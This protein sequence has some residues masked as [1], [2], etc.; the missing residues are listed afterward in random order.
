[1]KPLVVLRTGDPPPSIVARRGPF[2][3]WIKREVGDRWAGPWLEHDVRTGAPP[4]PEEVSGFILTGSSHSVTERAPWMLR[5][6]DLVRRAHGAGTPVFGICFGH[7][8][9]GQALGGEVQ[10]N[11]RGREIGTVAVRLLAA[12]S[13]EPMLRGLGTPFF[14]NHSHKDSVVTLPAG[15]RVLGETDLEPHAILDFG[16]RTRSVQFHPE[17]D[18]DVMRGYVTERAHLIDEEGGDAK[19]ILTSATDAPASASILRNFVTDFVRAS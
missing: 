17:F 9:I 11:P 10:L 5:T 2:S 13:G 4:S 16:A 1:M 7:Q 14:A 15:A 8:L 19:A 6:E 12:A 18:G 3:D